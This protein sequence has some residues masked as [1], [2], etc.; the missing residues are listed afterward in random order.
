M[1]AG[2][3][4]PRMFPRLIYPETEMRLFVD[5]KDSTGAAVNPTTVTLLTKSPSGAETEYV[6]GT[7]AEIGK[8][9]T[10]TYTADLVPDEHG[11]WRYR[12]VTTVPVIAA[13]G[14]FNVQYSPFFDAIDLVYQR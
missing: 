2:T 7:D 12:W 8:P 6:Y 10:G 3:A 13:E 5:F 11:L 9:S 4:T 1:A 14:T